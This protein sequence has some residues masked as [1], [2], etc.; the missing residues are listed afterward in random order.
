MPAMPEKFGLGIRILSPVVHIV[1]HGKRKAKDEDELHGKT[2]RAEAPNFT[3][4]LRLITLL[5]SAFF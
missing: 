1:S 5:E 4:P 2:P 3:S